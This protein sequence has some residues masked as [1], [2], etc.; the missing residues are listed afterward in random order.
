MRSIKDD[1]SRHVTLLGVTGSGK[2]F[3]MANVINELNRPTLVLSHN[4]TLAGQ[5]YNE[6][7]SFFPENAVEFFVSY[8]DYYQ[9]EAY[10]PQSDTYI[11]KDLAINEEIEKLRL[12]TASTL[13]SGRRDVVVVSSV[14]CL[15]GIGNPSD[16]HENTIN[17]KV[18]EL[19][20]RQ[21]FLQKMTTALYSRDELDFKPGTFKVKGDTID[22]HPAYSDTIYRVVFNGE[23]VEGIF[24]TDSR[25]SI[26]KEALET[27][28]LYPA[29]NFVTS[30]ERLH[31]AI[32]EIQ[33]DLY[34]RVEYFNSIGKSI[35]AGR[36]KSPCGVRPRNDKEVG[37]CS[38]I[39]NYSRYFDG[40]SAGSRP[41]CLLD[42]F[43]DDYLMIIDESHVTVPQIRAMYGGDYARKVNLVDY[44]F[45]LPSAMDNR[46]LKFDEFERLQGQ[47]VYASATPAD[48][49]LAK[50]E[51]VVVEQI[52][53]PTGLLDPVIEVKP[54]ENQIDDI[55]VQIRE[56]ESYGDSILITTLSP[57][58]WPKS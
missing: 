43:P 37:Y 18:G 49:E 34:D 1:N 8:Y 38:G 6:F 54:T 15:Y 42:Y 31:N 58:A 39:E 40:R 12:S 26:R 16:F 21:R 23:R 36:L 50:S 28:T 2:T 32:E 22:I 17:V 35:E 3:T 13:L 53:R 41:F 57:S 46:P 4:K 14:S 27:L 48:F 10:L 51:G 25:T 44:G 29:S 9:P 47:T 11:E 30:P 24:I 5:L 52:I 33:D 20:G 7:K 55:L 45:R 19:F 56:A